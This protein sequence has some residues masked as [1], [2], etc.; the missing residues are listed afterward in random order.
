MING[1]KRA[2]RSRSSRRSA[3][4]LG[5]SMAGA[6]A[7]AVSFALPAGA[8]TGLTNP[9]NSTIV[10]SGS[11]TTYTMMQ[12]LDTLFNDAPGCPLFNPSAP[13]QPLDYACVSTMLGDPSLSPQVNAG[14]TENPVN[15]MATEEAA[16]GSSNGIAQL[17]DQGTHGTDGTATVAIAN[18]QSFARSSRKIGAGDLKGLNF[19]AYATDGVSWFH[20]TKT[21]A[22]TASGKLKDLSK[23]DLINIWNGTY[24][25]WNQIVDE[26]KAPKSAPIVVYSAQEGS[27][28]QS[29]WKSYLGFDPSAHSQPVNCQGPGTNNCAGPQNIFENEDA[30]IGNIPNPN[31]GGNTQLNVGGTVFN[32]GDVAIQNDAI[33]FFSFGKFSQQCRAGKN[34]C[35]GSPLPTGYKVALGTIAGTPLNSTTILENTWPVQRY[36]YNVYSNGSNNKIPEASAATLNYVSENGFVC[37]PHTI[38]QTS[39]TATANQ[40]QDPN[41]GNWFRPEIQSIIDNNGFYAISA[42]AAGG[43]ENTTPIDAGA[44][45]N[46]AYKLLTTLNNPN[47]NTKQYGLIYQDG[48]S[49][50]LNYAT[51][52]AA[53]LGNGD[54]L[55][56][57]LVTTTDGN[58]NS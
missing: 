1:K 33:F 28:T 37:K 12:G 29:T 6:M 48:V 54:A 58:A 27:G 24:K 40:I 23:Q 8:V 3:V 2:L 52:D 11:S 55:G 17:Q 53:Q 36:L 14:Y 15:D 4:M 47:D 42:G 43:T 39:N 34:Q 49:T 56:F 16:I 30:Q 18:N 44:V 51:Y 21:T 19:A 35:G 25:N 57:C 31:F 10:G 7:V 45:G 5:A 22:A 50:G 41:T 20:F 26:G 38:D 9:A 46:G 13:P 32:P